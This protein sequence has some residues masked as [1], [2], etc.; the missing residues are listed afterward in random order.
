M[1]VELV[2]MFDEHIDR[3]DRLLKRG[4]RSRIF[5][6]LALAVITFILLTSHTLETWSKV[7][8]A[9][10]AAFALLVVL[11][12]DLRVSARIKRYMAK[13]KVLRQK[14]IDGQEL[15]DADRANVMDDSP[16]SPVTAEG[17]SNAA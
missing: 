15:T 17:A 12:Y 8:N 10:V 6:L 5:G 7:L 4:L 11:P 13:M 14:I 2:N 1:N 9:C 3:C 16:T